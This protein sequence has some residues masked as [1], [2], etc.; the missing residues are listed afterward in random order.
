MKLCQLIGD[1]TETTCKNFEKKKYLVFL[2]LLLFLEILTL[3]PQLSNI[4]TGIT[5]ST[6]D[7]PA[8]FY[9]YFFWFGHSM[10]I[11]IKL[12]LKIYV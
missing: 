8:M 4:S 12:Y 3:Q 7:N 2:E 6:I 11:G 9:F 10:Y 5:W 1:D